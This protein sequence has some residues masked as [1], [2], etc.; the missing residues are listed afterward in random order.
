MKTC[1]L[2]DRLDDQHRKK[3]EWCLTNNPTI[4]AAMTAWDRDHLTFEEA[5]IQVIFYLAEMVNEFIKMLVEQGMRRS[6]TP[7]ILPDPD[8]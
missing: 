3:L 1:E 4:K 5:S 6:D 8:V 7:T 2:L